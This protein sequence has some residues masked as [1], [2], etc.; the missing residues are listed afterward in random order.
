V[1]G[2]ELLRGSY[3]DD[4]QV[5]PRGPL[6]QVFPAQGLQSVPG[7]EVV[8]DHLL[9]LGPSHPGEVSQRS[10]EGSDVIA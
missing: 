6:D 4:H 3:V 7:D 10:N 1:A 2:D 9:H 8:T 5:A